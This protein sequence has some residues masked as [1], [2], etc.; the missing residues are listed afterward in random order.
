MST[1][2]SVL[3]G[4]RYD[5]RS[6]GDVDFDQPQLVHYL[7]RAI[8]IL[9]YMLAQH[10]SDW[11]LN[12][13][14]T[15]LSSGANSATVPT[16]AFNIR[17]VWISEDRKE[18]LDQMALYYKRE[19]R[20]SDTAE[21]NFWTH[22]NDNILFEVTANAAYTVTVYYDKLSSTIS[23]E[24]STMPYEGRFDEHLRE[25]VV[26]MAQA[27]KYKNPQEAD[28][29]YLKIFSDIVYQDTVNRK[30]TKK[31]YRLDF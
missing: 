6:Y 24:N 22:S 12:T 20:E 23:D 11:T 1:A 30:F 19:F 25:A 7:N 16:S 3:D 10:N 27:K 15:T 18:F 5:L 4:I 28:A 2:S 14:T 8:R 21:P 29:L 31:N 17:E 26:L 13:G 9:D